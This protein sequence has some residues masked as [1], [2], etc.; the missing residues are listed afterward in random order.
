MKDKELLEQILNKLGGIETML[1]DMGTELRSNHQE[2]KIATEK[3]GLGLTV[4]NKSTA[5]S[6]TSGDKKPTNKR[7]LTINQWF[8]QGYLD[9]DKSIKDLM[10][11]TDVEVD[12][13]AKKVNDDNSI[14]KKK[15]KEEVI[16]KRIAT[17]IWN[18]ISKKDRDPFKALHEEYKT[19]NNEKSTKNLEKEDI[20][21]DDE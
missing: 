18:K 5:S 7:G 15:D 14:K 13:I 9:G 2:L 10:E 19:K 17:S 21:D 1:K 4:G 6:S 16:K 8:I 12:A 11:T 20:S 3:N